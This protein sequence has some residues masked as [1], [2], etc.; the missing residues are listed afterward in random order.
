MTRAVVCPDKFRGSLSASAA[1]EAMAEGLR[2]GGVDDVV[3]LPLADGGE[4]TLD[5][6]STRSGARGAPRR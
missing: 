5:A 6:C 3:A 1:A 2:R 4:G